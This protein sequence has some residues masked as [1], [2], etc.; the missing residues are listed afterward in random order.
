M[1][2]YKDWQ[3]Y[4]F[5]VKPGLTGIWQVYGRSRLPFDAAQFLDLC[6]ALKRSIGLNTRLLLKTMPVIMLGKGGY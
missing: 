2:Y 6:Y 3:L 5:T 1:Q 4:R